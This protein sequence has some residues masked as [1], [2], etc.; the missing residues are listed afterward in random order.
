MRRSPDEVPLATVLKG[1]LQPSHRL[2]RSTTTDSSHYCA[3]SR[4]APLLPKDRCK[5]PLA[6]GL[7]LSVGT[8]GRRCNL[9]RLFAAAAAYDLV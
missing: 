3:L 8:L 6:F 9:P 5:Q 1:R 7:F 2:F 4:T